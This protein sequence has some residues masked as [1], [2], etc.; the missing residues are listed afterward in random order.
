MKA[1]CIFCGSSAGLRP[2]Y[3]EAA[4]ELGALLAQSRIQLVYGGGNIGLMGTVADSCMA[5]DGE[6][7]E[8]AVCRGWVQPGLFADLLERHRLFF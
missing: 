4:A 3:Q 6:V 2:A 7:V 8:D 1:I 5:A